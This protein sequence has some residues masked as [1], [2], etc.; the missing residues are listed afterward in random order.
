MMRWCA[1][2]GALLL[3]G[4]MVLAFVYAIPATWVA[5]RLAS[6]TGSRVQLAHARG[7]WHRGSGVLVLASGVGGADAVHTPQRVQWD[8]SPQLWPA[9]WNLRLT[10]PTFGPPLLATLS[11]GF[12][13]WSA[14]VDAWRGT[15][16]LNVLA[17]LG[18]P[19]NTLGLGGVAQINVSALQLSSAASAKPAA[20]SNVEV[21]LASVRSALAQ[22]LV[23][24][25]YALHGQID[26]AGGDFVL[27]TTQGALLLDGKGQC[28]LKNRLSCSFAGT[29]RAARHDDALLGNLLGLLGKPQVHD[30]SQNPGS[31]NPVTELRW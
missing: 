11:L 16:P 23:L 7:L 20:Q 5:Q 21:T 2:A 3:M 8:V 6:A 19:F 28:R 4:L 10:S 26:A 27:R 24:G 13:G 15:L 22:G 30:I 25:D 14:D 18:A 1:A 29:A 9:R 17:G 12:S 31:K